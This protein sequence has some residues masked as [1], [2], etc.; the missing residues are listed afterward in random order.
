MSMT[1]LHRGPLRGTAREAAERTG[2]HPAGEGLSL[3]GGQGGDG[4]VA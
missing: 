4:T 2:H 1:S 3:V